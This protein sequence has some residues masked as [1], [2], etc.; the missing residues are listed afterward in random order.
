MLWK[1]RVLDQTLFADCDNKQRLQNY[2][3]N[4]LGVADAVIEIQSLCLTEIDI[5]K[6][7]PEVLVNFDQRCSQKVVSSRF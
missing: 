4:N 5:E 7:N 1:V 3:E 2:L 6:F